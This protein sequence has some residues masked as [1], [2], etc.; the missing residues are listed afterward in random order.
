MQ[1][2]NVQGKLGKTSW[3]KSYLKIEPGRGGEKDTTQYKTPVPP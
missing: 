1:R 3:I 2:C